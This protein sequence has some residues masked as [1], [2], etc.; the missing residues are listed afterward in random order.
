MAKWQLQTHSGESSL[1]KRTQVDSY[2]L[3]FFFMEMASTS[4]PPSYSNSVVERNNVNIA[5]G[6]LAVEKGSECLY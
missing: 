3:C 5:D 2:F 6:E 1:L 4:H